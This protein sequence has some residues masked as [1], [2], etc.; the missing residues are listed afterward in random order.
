MK[1]IGLFVFFIGLFIIVILCFGTIMDTVETTNVDDYLKYNREVKTNLQ[2]NFSNSLPQKDIVKES[3]V[4]HY[5]YY[6]QS[7]ILGD[8][9]FVI[10]LKCFFENEELSK[11]IQR[12]ENLSP[13]RIVL[14]NETIYI[15]N[16]P[17]NIDL[18]FD[19]ETYDGLDFCFEIVVI[20]DKENSIEYL[21]SLQRD[22]ME[23]NK[24]VLDMVKKIEDLKQ[25]RE[26]SLNEK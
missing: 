12:I 10:N 20:N 1:K 15:I 18:L 21:S 24:N 22:N 5:Y 26:S 14:E 13:D 2:N 4:D 16:Y 3:L 17:D 19:D 25:I 7:P 8:I 11:E 6:C 23:L 9:T